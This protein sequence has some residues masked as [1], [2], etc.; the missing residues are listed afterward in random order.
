MS[1]GLPAGWTIRIEAVWARVSTDDG[2]AW[3]IT[4]SDTVRELRSAAARHT[5]SVPSSVSAV[6]IASV[7]EAAANRPRV[8]DD[9][10]DA[11][12]TVL[13]D[14]LAP[15]V[16]PVVT[17][18]AF[19]ATVARRRSIRHLGPVTLDDLAAVLTP[20]FH[21]AAFDTADDGAVRRFRPLPSAGAR[22]PV[23]PIVLAH[24]VAGLDPGMWRLAADSQT[25]YRCPVDA[26]ALDGAWNTLIELAGLPHRPGAAVV[27]AVDAWATL[28]RYPAGISLVWRDAGA[29]AAMLT[30]V[31]TDAGVGS[32]IVG[33]AGLLSNTALRT[34]GLHG[35]L[36]TDMGAVVLGAVDLGP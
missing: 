21:L 27:L 8:R 11:T 32:C 15:V 14:D 12:D 2:R 19:T 29:A 22:H 18:T 20:V 24:D 9:A 5:G 13:P 4:D 25:L 17:A 34:A 16:L 1:E 6:A 26:D 3:E 36:V 33:T 7:A 30:L 35:A 10:G 23:V 28:S 31:A